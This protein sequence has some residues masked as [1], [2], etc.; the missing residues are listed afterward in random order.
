MCLYASVLDVKRCAEVVLSSW[1]VVRGAVLTFVCMLRYW[2][3]NVVP[4]L[5]QWNCNEIL[6]V[7]CTSAELFL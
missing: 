1:V 2:M 5:L 7:R 4:R 3:W 6:D